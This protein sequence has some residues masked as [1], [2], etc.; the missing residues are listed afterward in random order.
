[1]ST[2]LVVSEVDVLHREHGQLV[3]TSRVAAVLHVACYREQLTGSHD[4]RR[5]VNHDLVRRLKRECFVLTQG[6]SVQGTVGR[7]LETK[8][9]R[10]KHIR[11]VIFK[12]LGDI[13]KI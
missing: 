6:Q 12:K 3:G 4:V 5:S 9:V 10:F 7:I 1:M 13:L 11:W 8:F 2:D